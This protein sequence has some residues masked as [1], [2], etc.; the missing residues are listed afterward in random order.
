MIIKWNP[1]PVCQ[2]DC[3]PVFWVQVPVLSETAACWPSA[4]H[5][6]STVMCCFWRAFVHVRPG[7][8]GH[9]LELSASLHSFLTI[10][11]LT[12]I[13]K[14]FPHKCMLIGGKIPH[15]S[16]FAHL[17]LACI[18]AEFICITNDIDCTAINHCSLV[19][20]CQNTA[21]CL[22]LRLC[23]DFVHVYGPVTDQSWGSP[24]Q[25]PGGDNGIPGG[26]RMGAP[27]PLG[28]RRNQAASWQG[29]P[30]PAV[31]QDLGRCCKWVQ[32]LCWTCHFAT[33][34]AC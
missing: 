9:I 10:Q 34:Q 24:V 14:I 31:L 13:V 3:V 28:T 23:T 16:P 30:C 11:S 5:C 27:G 32:S 21:D 4:C 33:N 20:Q 29:A 15:S 25:L 8:F 18:C 19:Q 6:L 12:R 1:L 2:T 17:L 22:L 26:S 7:S